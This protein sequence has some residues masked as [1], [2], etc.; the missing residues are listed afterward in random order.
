MGGMVGWG[1]GVLGLPRMGRVGVRI[2]MGRLC[3]GF[4]TASRCV[5]DWWRGV[6]CVS[7]CCT[8]FAL[9]ERDLTTHCA[10][11]SGKHGL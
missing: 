1:R 3:L 7:V 6:A 4:R 10:A 11:Q 5:W 2:V 8:D 9:E